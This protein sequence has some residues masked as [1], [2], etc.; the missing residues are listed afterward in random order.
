M[1]TTTLLVAGALTGAAPEQPLRL[2]NNL[3]VGMTKPEF[4][5][6]YPKLRTELGGGCQADVSADF[7]RVG[8]ERAK[9][10]WSTRDEHDRCAEVVAQSLVAKYGPAQSHT[11]DFSSGGSCGSATGGLAGALSSLCKASGGEDPVANRYYTWLSEG[12][13]ITLKVEARRND[14]WWLRYEAAVV[15]SADAVQKL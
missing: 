12:V 13:L 14:R 7:N 2:W 6:L 10:E 11:A 8:L 15:A 5:A 3:Y 4:K 9:L 1:L